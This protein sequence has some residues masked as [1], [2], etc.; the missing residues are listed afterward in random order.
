MFGLKNKT[1]PTSIA[2]NKHY[3]ITLLIIYYKIYLPRYNIIYWYIYYYSFIDIL[4][5][6]PQTF[7]IARIRITT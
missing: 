4:L 5:S 7:D 2:E 6:F 3:F 1:E